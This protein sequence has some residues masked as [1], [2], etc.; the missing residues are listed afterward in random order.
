[1]LFLILDEKKLI[2]VVI[3]FFCTKKK[4][5]DPKMELNTDSFHYLFTIYRI[6]VVIN[7][8]SNPTHAHLFHVACIIL[9]LN[10][11]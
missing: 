2:L 5:I 10:N 3:D 9:K 4:E 1:M 6:V 7:A 11:F 8:S